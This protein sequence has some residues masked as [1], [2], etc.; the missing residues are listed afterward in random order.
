M[1]IK[2]HVI[3]KLKTR[4]EQAFEEVYTL[5]K[6]GVYIIIYNVVK[7]HEQTQDLM[8]DAYLKMLNS[9]DQ[10][11]PQTNFYNWLLM[12]A[13]NSALDFYRREKKLVRYETV[14][15]DLNFTTKE[16][17]PDEKD[18]FERLL[19]VLNDEERQIIL[20]KIVDELKHREIAK[21]INKPLG[22]VIWMYHEALKKMK[23]VR[24]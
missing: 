21:M 2:Q 6:K 11:K 1:I 14:D 5:T 17:T 18:Q 20:F 3:E 15:Y 12:I 22:T 9:I 16:E 23:E 10:Y 8:Q 13:K 4:D 19:S 7:S 24:V